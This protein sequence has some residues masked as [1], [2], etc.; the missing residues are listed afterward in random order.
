MRTP[1]QEL[2][3]TEPT[4]DGRHL[5]KLKKRRQVKKT[6]SM[7]LLQPLV[8]PSCAYQELLSTLLIHPHPPSH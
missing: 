6:Q 7:P 2:L 3:P 8:E 4:I 5:T 1:E